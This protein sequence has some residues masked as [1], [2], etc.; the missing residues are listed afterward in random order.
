MAL[1][2]GGLGVAS[3]VHVFI[4]GRMDTVAVLRCLGATG[5][6][7]LAAYLVQAAAAAL[8][9]GLA[10]AGLGV[11]VQVVLPRFLKDFL[12]VDVPW[13]LSWPSVLGGIGIGLWVALVFSL[14]PLLAVRRVSPLGVLRRAYEEDREPR[15]DLARGAAV[16][17]LAASLVALAVIQAGR[18]AYGLGFAAGVGWRWSCCGSARSFSSGACVASSLGAFPTSSGRGSPTSIVPPTRP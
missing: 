15:R 9:G 5:G 11:A 8:V 2:L 16:L 13:S 7:V 4:K 12:P 18:L 17:A 14:L 6:T 1:L 10:G 3:A